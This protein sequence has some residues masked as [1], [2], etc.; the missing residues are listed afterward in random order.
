MLKNQWKVTMVSPNQIASKH[1][2]CCTTTKAVQNFCT[3]YGVNHFWWTPP[4]GTRKVFMVD[5]QS[6]RTC[7]NQVY[8]QTTT[9]MGT[10]TR[11]KS[12]SYKR[13]TSRTKTNNPK[14]AKSK[15]VHKVHAFHRNKG[16][17]TTFR[18]AA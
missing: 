4:Q 8:G 17:K 12:A 13:T 3:R 9:T 18:R 2:R 14:F 7:W 10:R 11:T 16:T 6:F 1:Y 5:F 15:V